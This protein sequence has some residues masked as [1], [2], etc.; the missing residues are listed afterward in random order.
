MTPRSTIVNA[1]H[2]RKIEAGGLLC[3]GAIPCFL[4]PTSIY[5]FGDCFGYLNHTVYTLFL[6]P[7]NDEREAFFGL[8]KD[9]K[10]PGVKTPGLPLKLLCENEKR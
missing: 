7:C 10:M 3:S 8:V 9:K 1:G 6:A 2:I 4:F 5:N